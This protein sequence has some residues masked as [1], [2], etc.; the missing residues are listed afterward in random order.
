MSA[1]GSGVTDDPAADPP[2]ERLA[3]L[4]PNTAAPGR[5][6]VGG[7]CVGMPDGHPPQMGRG[8]GVSP[9]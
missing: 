6:Q 7:R 5:D 4:T 9:E 3:D 8:T 2:R 1:A